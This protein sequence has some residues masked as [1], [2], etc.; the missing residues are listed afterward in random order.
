M[1][2]AVEIKCPATSHWHL[3]V[4]VRD[5]KYDHDAKKMTDDWTLA[6]SFVLKQGEIRTVYLTDSRKLEV[7]EI[8]PE[9]PAAPA[10]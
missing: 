9:K 1:T 6:D 4:E 10:D 2:T 5:R 7:A 3:K 8:V